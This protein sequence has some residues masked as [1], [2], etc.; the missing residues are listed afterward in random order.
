MKKLQ[1]V[2]GVT[3]STLSTLSTLLTLLTISIFFTLNVLAQPKEMTLHPLDI[4]KDGL[5]SKDEAQVDVTLSAIFAE[6]DS[7]QDGYLSHLELEVKTKDKT[8]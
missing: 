5:L 2:S 4:D 7:N 3:L 6:L 1:I 8:D